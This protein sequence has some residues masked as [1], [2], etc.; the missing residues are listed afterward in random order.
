MIPGL[1][2][3]GEVDNAETRTNQD[4]CYSVAE[5]LKRYI[6]IAQY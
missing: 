2:G 5:N 1:R 3:V 4:G 6:K